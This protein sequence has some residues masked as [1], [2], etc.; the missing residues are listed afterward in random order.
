MEQR[1]GRI[2]RKLQQAAEVFCY[3]FV[4]QQRPEDRIL[5]TVVRKT[6][7]IREELGSL[8]RVIDDELDELFKHGIRRKEIDRLQKNVEAAQLDEEKG[9]T[10]QDELESVRERQTISGS[11][12]PAPHYDGAFAEEV[13]LD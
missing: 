10:L 8:S 3:Y 11:H 6:K 12:R 4:Y 7:T 1:N 13:G 2:D 5:E 9:Q